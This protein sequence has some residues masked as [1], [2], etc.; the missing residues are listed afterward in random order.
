M[1][2]Q[3]LSCHQQRLDAFCAS[4]AE[5]YGVFYSF[6]DLQCGFHFL[7]LSRPPALFVETSV[8]KE[9]VTTLQG[10]YS[11]LE[12]PVTIR[13]DLSPDV[14]EGGTHT[15]VP[16]DILPTYLVPDITIPWK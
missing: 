14:L 2:S 9:L 11:T 4:F 3:K 13:C 6:Y 10:W 1:T 8:L 7:H 15:T 16:P 5:L 12:A